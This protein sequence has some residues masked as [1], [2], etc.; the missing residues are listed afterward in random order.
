M[1]ALG[2]TRS[3]SSKILSKHLIL[4]QTGTNPVNCQCC[5]TGLN[6]PARRKRSK[7][8]AKLAMSTLPV[9]QRHL[10]S[11]CHLERRSPRRPESKDLRLP[12]VHRADSSRHS[13]RIGGQ[14]AGTKS[15]DRKTFRKPTFSRLIAGRSGAQTASHETCRQFSERRTF[16]CALGAGGTRSRKHALRSLCSIRNK[17]L[18]DF[19]EL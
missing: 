18:V 13:V 15:M 19:K 5:R 10:E 17:V 12:C 16:N 14:P 2:S 1:A 8:V 7:S 11:G 3:L 9:I 4:R 6:W